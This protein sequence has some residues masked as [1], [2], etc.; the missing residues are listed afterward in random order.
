MRVILFLAFALVVLAPSSAAKIPDPAG[1][2]HPPIRSFHKYPNAGPVLGKKYWAWKLVHAETCHGKRGLS[3]RVSGPRGIQRG[4][5]HGESRLI[6]MFHHVGIRDLFAAGGYLYIRD[7]N[8]F[9]FDYKYIPDTRYTSSHVIPAGSRILNRSS[10]DTTS[11]FVAG[12]WLF[13]GPCSPQMR[14]KDPTMLSTFQS[15]FLST[16]LLVPGW[17][18]QG[19]PDG[20]PVPRVVSDAC[21]DFDLTMFTAYAPPM[22]WGPWTPITN[23]SVATRYRI[24]VRPVGDTQILGQVRFHN[25]AGSQTV[26]TFVDRVTFTTGDCLANVWVRF[27]GQPLGST[28]K[29]TI[30]EQPSTSCVPQIFCVR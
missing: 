14:R 28:V 13:Q 23:H 20:P 1:V 11:S 5:V 29:G 8:G 6:E 24:D 22:T 15:L 7:G 26:K 17:Q 16:F 27:Q 3:V 12:Q 2:S 18:T 30:H 4:V 10:H 9:G 25:R 19:L 21:R